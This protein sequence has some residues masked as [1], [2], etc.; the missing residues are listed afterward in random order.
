M[1]VYLVIET[2]IVGARLGARTKFSNALNPEPCH[3]IKTSTCRKWRQHS[4]RKS[5]AVGKGADPLRVKLYITGY[6]AGDCLNTLDVKHPTDILVD[7]NYSKPS[8]WNSGQFIGSFDRR[9]P[10][11]L[12]ERRS[13][14]SEELQFVGE[15]YTR[16]HYPP[17][18]Q[19]TPNY[20]RNE[21]PV[22]TSSARS[23]WPGISLNKFEARRKKK[24]VI[25]V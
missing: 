11:F 8:L 21:T 4:T 9:D 17:R 23:T 7:I 3:E 24:E 14:E 25:I 1:I 13:K 12:L 2:A 10:Y 5:R 22:K 6:L 20:V 18:P 16:T 19:P 15:L